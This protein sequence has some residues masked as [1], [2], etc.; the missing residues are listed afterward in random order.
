MFFEDELLTKLFNAVDKVKMHTSNQS[1]TNKELDEIEK[2]RD[3]DGFINLTQVKNMDTI[4][5]I[6]DLVDRKNNLEANSNKT[7]LNDV[8]Q[9]ILNDITSAFDLEGANLIISTPKEKGEAS[10]KQENNNTQSNKNETS[11][12]NVDKKTNKH[13]HKQCTKHCC[14]DNC[15]CNENKNT[16]KA[17][18]KN[19]YQSNCVDDYINN[20]KVQI[21]KELFEPLDEELEFERT[22]LLA[23][24]SGMY[25]PQFYNALLYICDELLFPD[26]GIFCEQD[27]TPEDADCI[28]LVPNVW[29]KIDLEAAIFFYQLLDEKNIE[30]YIINP[31]TFEL[32]EIKTGKE[33]MQYAMTPV[34]SEITYGRLD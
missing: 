9:D 30:L 16:D 6:I 28:V 32:I 20:K 2:Y 13:Q 17:T 31:E 21:D 12:M 23:D 1:L 22:V 8:A 19:D 5:H 4:S 25:N 33:L 7:T 24:V 27:M 18:Y 14:S 10:F 34:Q 3:D 26:C 15:K 29:N 11:N